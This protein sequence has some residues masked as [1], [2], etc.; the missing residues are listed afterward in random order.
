MWGAP[1]QYLFVR[2]PMLQR[3]RWSICKMWSA[4]TPLSREAENETF[5]NRSSTCRFRSSQ[6]CVF[7][8]CGRVRD[9]LQRAVKPLCVSHDPHALIRQ[10]WR[11]VPGI[12]KSYL[13]IHDN[14]G[15]CEISVAFVQRIE[16]NSL[17]MPAIAYY[18]TETSHSSQ[19][20]YI[21]RQ[22][23]PLAFPSLH[24]LSK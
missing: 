3:C 18:V 10:K 19:K 9:R 11:Q 6:S 24:P 23:Q 8:D 16:F 14:F 20:Y 2:T 12:L 5:V 7:A 15:M 13:R 4:T 22:S 21:C 17:I 1:G